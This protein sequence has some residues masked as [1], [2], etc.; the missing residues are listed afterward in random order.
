MINIGSFNFE[1]KAAIVAVILKDPLES[2]KKAAIMGADIVEIRLDLLKIK[3]KDIAAETIRKVRLETGLPV[4][5]TNRSQIEGGK[6]EGKEA[7][8]ISLL[9][10]LIAR[11]NGA[12]AVDIELSTEWKARDFVVETARAHGKTVIVSSHDFSKTPSFQEMESTLEG[13]FLAGADIAKIAVMPHS[14]RD[15][16]DLLELTLDARD[17]GGAVCTIAMGKLGEHTR[18]I[19]PFYGSILTYASVEGTASAVPGQLPV[20]KLKK[21]MELLE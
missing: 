13:A 3:D 16:L 2:S 7:E 1:K 18:M 8:R 6:W 11:E 15:V 5:I 21:A 20:D 9:V 17:A 4:I 19:A 12:D 14:L 10:D